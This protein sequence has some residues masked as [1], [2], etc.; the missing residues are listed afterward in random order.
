MIWL[1]NY[2]RKCFCKHEF[3]KEEGWCKIY[4][5]FEPKEGVRVSLLC[6]KCGY[7]KSFWK[8]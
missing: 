8:V 3:E 7:H 2:F 4:D 5:V 6:L 1:I